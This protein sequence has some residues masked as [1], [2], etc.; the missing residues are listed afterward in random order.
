MK[1][2]RWTN[3][4]I[5]TTRNII[6]DSKPPASVKKQMIDKMYE[7]ITLNYGSA[8]TMEK[9][10]RWY[11]LNPPDLC[12]PVSYHELMREV[13][14]AYIRGDYYPALTSACCLGERILN[15]LAIELKEYYS[16]SPHYKDIA[17][18]DSIQ[19]WEKAIRILS[20]WEVINNQ[21]ATDFAKLLSLRNPAVHFGNVKDRSSTAFEALNLIYSVTKSLFGYSI[22]VF[23]WAPGEIYISYEK[24][25]DPFTKTFLLPHCVKVGYNHEVRSV[26][27]GSI[28]TYDPGPY[29]NGHIRDEE[30]VEL[31]KQA[32]E[33]LSKQ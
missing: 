23:F 9:F 12:A 5:D 8:N 22:P 24:E 31:R 6:R 25:S 11:S 16:S 29:P 33:R 20:D 1:R 21:Q 4:F 32:L 19:D 17:R 10:D 3:F 7:F 26:E 30:F 2:Y 13:E 28:E 14:G 27:L 15:H 18:K